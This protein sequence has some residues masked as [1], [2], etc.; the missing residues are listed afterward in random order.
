MRGAE[1]SAEPAA[2]KPRWWLRWAIAAGAVV[3]VLILMVVWSRLGASSQQDTGWARTATVEKRDFVRSL[4]IH[5]TVA[6]V[7]S[8]TVAAPRL[9]GG[10][11]GGFGGGGGGGGAMIMF[12]GGGGGQMIITKLAPSGSRVKPG[13]IVVEF[14][15]QDQ[16]RAATDRENEY[17]DYE[18]QIN[19]MKAD[20]EATKAADETQMEQARNAVATAKLEMRKNE[21]ISKIDAEKNEQTLEET[22]ARL[23]QLQQTYDL[24]R[25]AAEAALRILEITRDRSQRAMQH[26]QENTQKMSIRSEMEGL[27]VLSTNFR[28]GGQ[29]ADV[30]EGDQVN[31]GFVILRVVDP[32]RMEVRARVNQADIANLREGQP[33]KVRLDAYP[34]LVFPGRLE[35]FSV[36]A[37]TS[38]L[39]SKVR[40]F[41]AYFSIN[42]SDPKLLPDLSAAVDVELERIPNA[43]ILPRDAVFTENNQTY[44]HARRGLGWEKRAVKTGKFSDYEVTIE[45]G[46]QPGDV[47]QR[48]AARAQGGV[49]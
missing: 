20:Q 39:S 3:V 36:I 21:V 27:V 31:A 15:P 14:D 23:K 17:K 6:A 32:D 5:G 22:E 30:Q 43:L 7:Q 25:T 10:T 33:V 11:R 26:A 44:V 13:D 34:D 49:S 28:P 19:K 35:R 45:S 40:Y 46:L 37:T 24:R 42:G 41:A 2:E 48:A 1:N 9:T 29:M 4:R 8:F 12:A 16:E 38:S 18:G 47:V